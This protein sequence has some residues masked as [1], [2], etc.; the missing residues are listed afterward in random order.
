MLLELKRERDLTLLFITHNIA[1]VEY[2]ADEMAVMHAGRI[3]ERGPTERVCNTPQ[4][5]YTRKLL[6]A[7]PRLRLN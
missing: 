6:A 1:V 5:E 2:L 7:V 3:I 4:Q